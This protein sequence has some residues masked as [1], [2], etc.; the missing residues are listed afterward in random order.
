MPRSE[1][2]WLEWI[3]LTRAAEFI[4]G[5]L[6]VFVSRMLPV[7]VCGQTRTRWGNRAHVVLSLFLLPWKLVLECSF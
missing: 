1:A 5:R 4:D 7:S 6:S 2:E 3:I